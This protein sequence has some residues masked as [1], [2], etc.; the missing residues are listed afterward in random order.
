MPYIYKS[1]K[2]YGGAGGAGA[3]ADDMTAQEIESFLDDINAEGGPSEY[4]KLLWTNPSPNSAFASQTITISNLT[5][6]S[7]IEI[8]AE[9]G[10]QDVNKLLNTSAFPNGGLGSI[11]A[12]QGSGGAFC[13]R[14]VTINGNQV[15]IGDGA[16]ISGASVSV[17]NK[18]CIPIKIYGI[19]YERVAPP[20]VEYP[21]YSTEEQQIGTWID[22]KPIY[23]KVIVAA[24][25][26]AGLNTITAPSNIDTLVTLRGME[27]E[28]GGAQAPIPKAHLNTFAYQIGMY[29]SGGYIYI[30]VGSSL[31]NITTAYII[32]EYTKTT[33]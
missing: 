28:S 16:L 3:S 27:K 17:S 21:N 4:R 1:G 11:I 13:M 12:S 33:D 14:T 26:T 31:T 15:T 18:N 7:G 24:S 5:D 8:V 25:I 2:K 10:L 9:Y 22:G 30:E 6:Y 20:Q 23:R 32:C 29:Y 19:K